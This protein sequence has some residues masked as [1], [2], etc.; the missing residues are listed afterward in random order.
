M[1]D[2]DI[3]YILYV[4]KSTTSEDQQM[5]SIADQEDY[6]TDFAATRDLKIV[7]ILRESKSAK[8]PGKRPVFREMINQIKGGNANGIIV[9]KPNRLS[10]NPLENGEI[11]QLLQD[12]VIQR[13]VTPNKDYVPS[14]HSMIFGIEAAQSTQFSRDLSEDVIRGMNRRRIAGYYPQRAPVG[15]LNSRGDDGL[16]VLIPDPRLFKVVQ[17][18]WRLFLAGTYTVPELHRVVT[19]EWEFRMP[20]RRRT[21]GNVPT[22]SW[23]YKMLTNPVYAGLVPSPDGLLEGKHDA[24]VTLSEYDRVQT[25][26]GRDGKPRPKKHEF[27]FSGQI[28]C[29]ECGCLNTAELKTKYIKSTGEVRT[30]I[31]YHCTRRK[32]DVPC[33]QRKVVSELELHS[34][35]EEHL[36]RVE[37]QPDHLEWALRILDEQS[38]DERVETEKIRK[39]QEQTLAESEKELKNLTSLLA[40]ERITEAEYFPRR[41]E[42][43]NEIT[44][45]K[46]SLKERAS[47][48]DQVVELTAKTFRFA[49]YARRNFAKGNRQAKR[50]ILEGLGSN[51]TI[52]AK[53]LSIQPKNWLE[54]I[55]EVYKSLRS[56]I[57]GFEPAKTVS[58]DTKIAPS[59]DAILLMSG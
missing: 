25:L 54:P 16:G 44:R 4:R 59:P 3:D 11:Q 30:Y 12:A 36:S 20:Q 14:D 6:L 21:G 29:G 24:M 33:T 51:R 1:K 28:H 10:R 43:L 18:M 9:W 41:E 27:T 23:I 37:I 8:A 13:I 40:R 52:M 53:K 58:T 31:Y 49:A 55:S 47:N 22:I 15:Y 42:L 35:I 34:Q 46:S 7:R 45:L 50:E 32:P 26:L 2:T 17:K 48:A 56:K 57:E 39:S 19:R 5:Q 38:K